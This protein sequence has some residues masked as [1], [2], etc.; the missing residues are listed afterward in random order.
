MKKTFA[1]VAVAIALSTAP[2]CSVSGGSSLDTK[3]RSSSL[4]SHA[5]FDLL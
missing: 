2:L 4:T 3:S 5:G 1:T